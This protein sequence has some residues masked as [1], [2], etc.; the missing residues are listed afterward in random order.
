MILHA[1]GQHSLLQLVAMFKEFLNNIV[2]KD[3]CHKLQGV[4][5]YFTE[6]LV[7]LVA[8]CRLEFLLNES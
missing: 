5:V 1:L 2:T 4:R 8:I 6:N 7:L 3:I